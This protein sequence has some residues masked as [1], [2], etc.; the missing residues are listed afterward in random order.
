MQD[1]NEKFTVTSL[2]KKLPA[3]VEFKSLTNKL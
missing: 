3:F 1:F 2:V